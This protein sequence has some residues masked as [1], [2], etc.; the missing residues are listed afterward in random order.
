[1]EH[2]LSL[3]FQP[4]SVNLRKRIAMTVKELKKRLIGKIDQTDNN[5]LLEE[6][7]RL[8]ANEETGDDIYELSV[9]QINA[10]E[11]GQLQYKNG[12]FLTEEQADKDIE[13]WL[14]K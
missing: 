5:E 13:E 8:I 1:M 12:R 4:N 14:D 10:V 7:Y 3:L 2:I 6:M 11:E 9:E